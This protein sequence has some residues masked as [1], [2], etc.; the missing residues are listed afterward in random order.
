M[1]NPDNFKFFKYFWIHHATVIMLSGHYIYND[2]LQITSNLL[3]GAT[4]LSM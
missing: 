2:F 3:I 1:I 4:P